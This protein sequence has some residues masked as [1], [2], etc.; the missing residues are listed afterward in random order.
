MSINRNKISEEVF[1]VLLEHVS[2][3]KREEEFDK[4]KCYLNYS[5][6]D[7]KKLNSIVGILVIDTIP[8]DFFLFYT[9][10]D[11]NDNYILV[12]GQDDYSDDVLE[13]E[14]AT[15]ADLCILCY[16]KH[17][18]VSEDVSEEE[19]Y[20]KLFAYE[21]EQYSGYTFEDLKSMFKAFS[22]YK[23]NSNAV[24]SEQSVYCIYAYW[25]LCKAKASDFPWADDTITEIE[26]VVISNNEVLPYYNIALSLST[27]Q[28]THVFLESYRIIEHAFSALYLKDV[29]T[30]L[31]IT[32]R[33][34][35]S[36]FEETLN[37]RPPEEQ[38][39]EK[40]FSILEHQSSF[41]GILS[42]LNCIKC[43]YDG[44]MNLYKWYYKNIRNRVAHFRIVHKDVEF[45]D[46]E[47]NAVIKF[48]FMTILFLY[49]EYKEELK[50]QTNN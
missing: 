45:N 20:N 40:I 34:M 47:W 16:E 37:W 44:E 42:V 19:I 41:G 49:N 31:N 9:R 50:N 39:I 1:N 35:A 5:S 13:K 48:N 27:K 11:T 21:D 38:S 23:L 15:L 6:E 26:K 25:L 33:D 29:S 18:Y 46:E 10:K 17:L 32:C 30:K 43:R 12:W 8:N 7:K 28:W 4:S 3:V 24:I 14:E 36:V 22:L 2:S